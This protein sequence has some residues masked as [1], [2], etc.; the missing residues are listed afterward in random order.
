MLC[1]DLQLLP[2]PFA[3]AN[4]KDKIIQRGLEAKKFCRPTVIAVEK[5]NGGFDLLVFGRMV[6]E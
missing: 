3:L 1:D 6:K 4:E 2:I 5:K